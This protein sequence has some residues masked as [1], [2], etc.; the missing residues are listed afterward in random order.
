MHSHGRNNA[1]V[2]ALN[3]SLVSMSLAAISKSVTR[4]CVE[5]R[6]PGPTWP[7]V[8]KVWKM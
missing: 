3:D 2:L 7:W 5:L 8:L 4:M 6:A 1:L